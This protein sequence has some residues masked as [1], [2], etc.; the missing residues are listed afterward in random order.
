[1]CTLGTL[2][3]L[4]TFAIACRLRKVINRMFFGLM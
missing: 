2:G 3:T 4:G 1:M